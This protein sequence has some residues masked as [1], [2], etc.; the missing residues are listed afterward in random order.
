MQELLTTKQLAGKLQV[1]TATIRNWVKSGKIR[2]EKKI[3]GVRRMFDLDRVLED[4][5]KKQKESCALIF[6]NIDAQATEKKVEEVVFL[7]KQFC[8]SKGWQSQSF[9]YSATNELYKEGFEHFL[10][11][12][13]RDAVDC[14]VVSNENAF[15][16]GAK[17]AIKKIC[18]EKNIPFLAIFKESRGGMCNGI[19]TH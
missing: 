15:P 16:C 14:V 4:I 17:I 10:D 3:P 12:L 2:P 6:V 8:V 5:G 11:S 19:A 13:L 1:H 7:A 18:E 9:F